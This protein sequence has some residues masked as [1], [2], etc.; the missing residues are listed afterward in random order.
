MTKNPEV[1]KNMPMIY[2]TGGL[3]VPRCL[4]LLYKYYIE[5]VVIDHNKDVEF[6]MISL[7]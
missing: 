7:F 2:D 6:F 1:I 5:N 3:E 4:L